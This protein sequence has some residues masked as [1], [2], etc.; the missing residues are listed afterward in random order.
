MQ[1]DRLKWWGNKLTGDTVF[2][3][4]RDCVRV[5]VSDPVSQLSPQ[6]SRRRRRK[7]G[8]GGNGRWGEKTPPKTDR[9]SPGVIFLPPLCNHVIN[10]P[11]FFFL[12][13]RTC[14]WCS[15]E[16]TPQHQF[17][18]TGLSLTHFAGSDCCCH[19][20]RSSFWLLIGAKRST[21]ATKPPADQPRC[22]KVTELGNCDATRRRC[23][24]SEQPTDT[25]TL[26][27]HVCDSLVK[28]CTTRLV[29][30]ASL[31]RLPHNHPSTLPRFKSDQMAVI[32]GAKSEL[33]SV[34]RRDR[35]WKQGAL[36]TFAT[37]ALRAETEINT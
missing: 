4:R 1:H 31:T 18:C 21:T 2:G 34:R 29:L 13:L 7:I 5:R 32:T 27:V 17:L 36:S 3:H 14:G 15:C 22:Q 35:P 10:S 37:Q 11:T 20:H 24:G 8:T 12:G 28:I 26:E 33:E 30:L 19:C 9:R 16:E 23:R 6:S 25:K